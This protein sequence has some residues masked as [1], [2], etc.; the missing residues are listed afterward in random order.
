MTTR[1]RRY[2]P[3]QVLYH[4]AIAVGLVVLTVTG[5]A[6]SFSYPGT[7][8][9]F[10]WHLYAAWL[11][12]LATV[13]HVWHDT[14]TLRSFDEMWMTR[15]TI[16][17]IVA[18]LR[19]LDR[20][21][22]GPKYGKY[23]P[24]QI[25][26][27]WL[28]VLDLLGITLT[29]FVLWQPS[30]AYVAPLW[31]PWGWA[32]IGYSRLVHQALTYGLVVLVVGHV[33]FALLVPKNWMFLRSILA[34][35]VNEATYAVRHRPVLVETVVGREPGLARRG[36]LK[37]SVAIA[38]VALGSAIL[39]RLSG[40][41]SLVSPRP[42]MAA[43]AKLLAF[44]SALCTGCQT[45]MTVCS[46]YNSGK[47]SLELA[48][49]VVPRHPFNS[50]FAEQVNYEPRPCLQ[51]FDAPCANACPVAAIQIDAASGTY[52][53]VIDERACI[54]CGRCVETCAALYGVG[55][56]KLDPDKGKAIKCHQCWGSPRCVSWCPNAA[57][58]YVPT[59][60]LAPTTR[61]VAGIRA[62]VEQSYRV[63]INED[64]VRELGYPQS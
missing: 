36:F 13:V 10:G 9:W 12:L 61:E 47:S 19:S 22:D 27:H 24:G 57:L 35:S 60:A 53:R 58:R 56:A 48:R 33:Y 2:T 16:R 1:I 34:G 21:P 31:L 32:A 43:P 41:A 38:V 18:R 30:R 46:T 4:W 51:C 50:T 29:G 37:G 11:F 62:M 59:A 8:W 25:V 6:I 55:R 17:D 23:A 45:C 14:V 39:G 54:G 28:L 5:L 42:A 63:V 26:F 52:A 3:I 64:R 44:D 20:G 49:L 15:Q 40:W 7:A